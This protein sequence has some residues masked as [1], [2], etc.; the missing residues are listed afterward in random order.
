MML[1]VETWSLVSYTLAH[2]WRTKKNRSLKKPVE[3]KAC[4]RDRGV[5]IA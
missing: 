5:L 1:V 2:Y 4:G 3:I